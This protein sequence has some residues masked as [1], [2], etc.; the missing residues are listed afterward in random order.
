[1]VPNATAGSL[2][3]LPEA[4]LRVQ[5]ARQQTYGAKAWGRYGFCDAFHPQANYY[6]PDVLGI[7]LGIG[8]LMAENLRTA[9]VRDTFGRNPEVAV[10][11]VRAGL[12]SGSPARPKYTLA[13]IACGFI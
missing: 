8:L 6:D 11:F 7:D 13:W 10:A 5:R 3:F 1:M 2:P 12:S 9:F 4:C